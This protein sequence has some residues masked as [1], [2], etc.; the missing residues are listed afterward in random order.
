MAKMDEKMTCEVVQ[1]LLPLYVDGACTEGSKRLVEEHIKDCEGCRRQLKEM[2]APFEELLAQPVKEKTETEVMLADALKKMRGSYKRVVAICLAVLLAIPLFVFCGRELTGQGLCLSNLE[3]YQ[4]TK[5]TVVNNWVEQG[6]DAAVDSM[7]PLWLY[8]SVKTLRSDYEIFARFNKTS[9][10]DGDCS[11]GTYT[12]LTLR[13]ENFYFPGEVFKDDGTYYRRH[14][15]ELYD[16]GDEL[17]VIHSLMQSGEVM[18]PESLFQEVTSVYNNIDIWMWEQL[19]LD[20]KI[21]YYLEDNGWRYQHYFMDYEAELYALFPDLEAPSAAF[22]ITWGCTVL[23]EGP[24]RYFE[25]AYAEIY[26]NYQA[27]NQYY[28]DMGYDGFR[29]IWRGEMKR[30][31]GELEELGWVVT[32]ADFRSIART[33]VST[34]NYQSYQY[35]SWRLDMGGHWVYIDFA[36]HDYGERVQGSVCYPMTISCYT[37]PEEVQEIFDQI[38]QLCTTQQGA[39]TITMNPSRW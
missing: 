11:Q 38:N 5:N 10:Y 24:Q 6:S 32:D 12:C 25:E 23:P 39:N 16:A 22:L 29:D 35:V 15:K 2:G 3:E 18:V 26:A 19:E 4:R 34:G 13:G 1:D 31:L 20:G 17:G 28:E 36:V 33:T 8:E 7:S 9:A 14:L 30:L 21:Y 37:A 27:Y